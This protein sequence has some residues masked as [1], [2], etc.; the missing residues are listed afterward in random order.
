[1]T[2]KPFEIEGISKSQISKLQKI[3]LNNADWFMIDLLLKVI[4]RFYEATKLLSARKYATLSVSFVIKKI[5]QNYLLN[6]T[7]DCQQ[8]K[9]LKQFL[10]SKLS[11][12]LDEKISAC[13]QRVTLVNWLGSFT[14]HFLQHLSLL[15]FKFAA[16]LDPVTNSYL[17]DNENEKA[18]NEIAKSFA[19]RAKQ[20]NTQA[21]NQSLDKNLKFYQFMIK[22]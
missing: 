12:H 3:H 4:S 7:E 2:T 21:S 20:S 5:F 14:I 6:T 9:I 17:D 13:H 16:Y 11:H 22:M 15:I 18:E 19:R 8:E 1:M 10:F